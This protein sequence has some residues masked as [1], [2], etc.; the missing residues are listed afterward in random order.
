MFIPQTDLELAVLFKLFEHCQS[1]DT[2]LKKDEI[3]KRFEF[4][5]GPRRV[6]LALGTMKERGTVEY[7]PNGT[8][9]S[10]SAAGYRQIEQALENS[11]TF[12]G[13]YY[14]L[15]DEWLSSRTLSIEGVPAS[16]RIVS[17]KHNQE[18]IKEI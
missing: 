2:R 11:D 5:V 9:W 6:E 12:V 7:F 15:G 17:R 3:A 13:N 14:R 4:P 16:N 10:I 1:S 18:A 8:A